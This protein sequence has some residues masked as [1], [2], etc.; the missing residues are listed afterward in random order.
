MWEKIK[1]L[2]TPYFILFYIFL[3]VIWCNRNFLIKFISSI[4]N[5]KYGYTG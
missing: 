2:F 3:I 4:F 5:G 1:I